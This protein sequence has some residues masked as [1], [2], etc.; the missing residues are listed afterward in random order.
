[1][2]TWGDALDFKVRRVV[3]KWLPL[4]VQ[5]LGY[6]YISRFSIWMQ[7]RI[8]PPGGVLISKRQRDCNSEIMCWLVEVNYFF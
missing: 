1:M 3:F 4:H 6:Y 2:R 7:L 8:L 5:I